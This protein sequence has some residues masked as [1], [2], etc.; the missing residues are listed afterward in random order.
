MQQKNHSLRNAQIKSIYQQV[1][2]NFT[3][4]HI[5]TAKSQRILVKSN[6]RI[7]HTLLKPD[8]SL[9]A[10]ELLCNQA[11]QYKLRA[12]CCLPKNIAQCKEILR[13][14]DI[15]IVSVIDFP[16][17]GALPRDTR[18]LAQSAIKEGAC[19][20][21]MVIPIASLKRGSF[22][23]VFNHI[24]TVTEACENIPV[25]VIVE[26]AYLTETELVSACAICRAAGASFVKTSTGFASRGASM[27]DI[28]IMK[29]AVG[30]SMGIKA[31][32][33]IKTASFAKQLVCSG[34]DVIGTSS[35]PQCLW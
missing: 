24:H 26:T 25:K 21:D 19:E 28:E 14:S 32:G 5:S 9:A 34:A 2:K 23:D 18:Y 13:N 12:V 35:G 16:L 30:D 27:R 33:G 31:S 29:T 1:L 17:G 4:T 20:I 3:I 11:L 7:E 15:L 22:N 6:T 10:I 8:A